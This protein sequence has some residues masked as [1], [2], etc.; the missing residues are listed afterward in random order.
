MRRLVL[1]IILF[2]TFLS[3]SALAQDISLAADKYDIILPEGNVHFQ[4]NDR[5]LLVKFNNGFSEDA[6]LQFFRASGLFEDYN[7]EWFLPSHAAYR[8][9][10]KKGIAWQQAIQ[11]LK[12]NTNVEY[13]APA[14]LYK[15]EEQYL[16]DLF[17]VELKSDADMSLLRSL[18][19][20]LNFAVEGQ[21]ADQKNM[22]RCRINKN[23]L[24]NTLEIAKQLQSLNKF[25]SAEPDFIYIC[26]LHTVDPFYG[27]QW[28]INNSGQYGGTAGADM[29][30]VNAWNMVTGS[31]SLTVAVH[32]CWGSTAE[33]T[34]PDINFSATYDAVGA[35][36]N[37]SGFSGDA[38]GI[39]CAGIIGAI[40]NNN[41]GT[42]GVAYG[43]NLAA[44]KIGT[45][46]N[47]GGSF[48][49]SGTI[50][51]L[52]TI[53]SYQNAD[54][55]SNSTGGGSSVTVF[56][57]AIANA[58]S[59]GRSGAGT[60]FLSSNGNS[61]TT[62]IGYPASNTNTI[63]V[64][65][66][67]MCDQRKSPTSCDGETWWGCDYG[68]G[69]DVGAPGVYW[70]ATDIAGSAGYSGNDYYQ[71]MNGTSS[72]CPAAAGVVA[73]ILSENPTL[74][75]ANTRY[76]LET[77][78]EKV[79]GYTYASNVSGQPNGTWSNELG[80][81]RVNAYQAV[82]AAD[83]SGVTNDNCSNAIS[84]P[85]NSSCS[86]TNGNF[87]RATQSMSPISCGSFTANRAADVWYTVVPSGT[88]GTGVT[89][90]C[91][92]GSSTDVVMALYSGN[93][94]GMTLLQCADATGTGGTETMTVTGLT[95]G[96]T[97]YVRLYDHN[98][99]TH[100]TGFQICAT[101]CG[102]T[103][104]ALTPS[105]TT[106]ICSGQ[107]Q[108]FTVSNPC[109]GCNY[110]WSN[111][112]TGTSAS[113]NTAGSY[114]ATATNS[115][116]TSST[117]NTVTLAVNPLPV[118]P[119]VT[120]AGP[121][122]LCAGQSQTLTISNPCTGCTFAWS[123][124]GTGTTKSVNT[125][126]TNTVTAS[127]SCGIS[128]ASNSVSVT[129]NPLPVV[130]TV[131]P[132]GPV[133]ICSGQSQTLT[134]SNPCTGCTFNWSN[135][136]TGTSSSVNTAGSYTVTSTNSCG[137]SANSNSVSVTVNPLPV[138]P[139]VTPTGPV[140]FCSGQ[141][142][143][144]TISNPCTGCTFNWSNGA[145]GTSTSVNTTGNYTATSTNSCGI[146]AASNSVAVTVNPLPVTPVITPAG[147]LTIC[148]G[149][150]QTLTVSNPCTGC[151]FSWSNGDTGISI[152]A[153]TAANYTVTATSS[154]GTTS[155]SN[156]VSLTVNPLPVTPVVT[157]AGPFNIC[158]NQFQTLTISNPCTGC[159][160]NWSN[161]ATGTSTTVNTTGNYTATATNSCGTSA[162]SNTVVM[163]VTPLP[164]SPLGINA[165]QNSI[166]VGGSTTLT[167]NGTLNTGETWHWY[168]GSC[169]GIPVGTGSSITVSPTVTTL[170]F[171]RAENGTCYSGCSFI[172]IIANPVPIANAGPDVSICSGTTV[173]LGSPFIPGHSYS[174]TP[175]TGLS[176]GSV[177]MP[178]ASPSATT[179]YTLI[180]T[181]SV[182]C[183]DTDL[184]VVS[185]NAQPVAD[186]GPDL[187][188]CSGYPT[189]IGTPLIPGFNYDWTPATYLNS[190]VVAMPNTMPTAPITYTL[191]VSNP[192]TG[193]ADTDV[194]NI[195]VNPLPTADAGPYS[196]INQQGSVQIGGTPTATGNGPFSYIWLPPLDL[197]SSTASNPIASPDTIRT[198]TVTVTDA[199]GCIRTDTVTVYVIPPCIPP[200]AS[201][202]AMPLVGNCPLTVSFQDQSQT[203]GA[204]TY[205]WN[206]NVNG[207]LQ[208]YTG[209]NPTAL[210]TVAGTY[211]AQLIVTDTCRSDTLYMPNYVTVSCPV[212][213]ASVSGN[214]A[215]DIFPNPAT[216]QLNINGEFLANGEYQLMLQNVLGQ[217]LATRKVQV[218]A[219]KLS[220]QFSLAPYAH[221]IYTIQLK[222]ADINISRKIEKR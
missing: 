150:S 172:N 110:T 218:V 27:N 201:F 108:T 144:L 131:T 104:P 147:P 173:T 176:S 217:T 190:A 118:V 58:L 127:N 3:A 175:T 215:I 31:S 219:G 65:A 200:T 82:L 191:I 199:N 61:N 167:V 149:Q 153:T 109:T 95:S 52:A 33:F 220:E 213:A 207:T 79:G 184:V 210:Y 88:S 216:N 53:W 103:T 152:N 113:I 48:S 160:F 111:S 91:V 32:D 125:T 122:T 98:S 214:A 59:L 74:S 1:P 4:V 212:S 29:E 45:I 18:A 119:T 23:S 188:A 85:L 141:S 192:G 38:H 47:S 169:G 71:Y 39:N 170:Y 208:T 185:V 106:T 55:I 67:S 157:P 132:A 186:A 135:G 133:T 97:Y 189:T 156:S 196:V 21:F 6:I 143:T 11:L 145:T 129:V 155:T 115:C 99:S 164:S 193:C 222:G 72:A 101:A 10:L 124:G 178:N 159:T 57:N 41:V 130:P 166:C 179:T 76:I 121:V 165:S 75:A 116:G 13:A 34:H 69:T 112:A 94:S 181:N 168:S 205:L 83:C 209:A 60:L 81:G 194:V 206:I 78:A 46:I 177:A 158:S 80:H 163:N 44:V 9:V 102:P 63:A 14:L 154:C 142:Q 123:G 16:Y 66:T 171:V 114:T 19:Q 136:A 93:C 137:T 54:V 15:G 87:C 90:S 40:G 96:T 2:C 120:P 70:H 25:K 203:S 183:A 62:T 89:L 148:A 202:T 151:S 180:I 105:G 139:T 37:S 5:K 20:Q 68:V 56:D 51:A 22:Y 161:G 128:A 204:T 134:I 198:Y 7:K 117:S 49:T 64:A 197:S 84:L 30:V 26:K 28:G 107:S 36:F 140:T 86:Y 162:N 174:W 146:S 12:Q 100:N 50:R 182:G 138:V 24:G 126:S 8:P 195:G 221:G 42:V 77:T 35:G 17:Y 187:M 92:S 211:S 43:V 73:L